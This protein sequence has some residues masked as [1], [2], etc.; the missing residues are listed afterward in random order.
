MKKFVI[1]DLDGTLLNTLEDLKDSTNFALSEFGYPERTLDEVRSFVGNGVRKL[2]ERAVPP[3]CDNVEEC[4]ECF[5]NHYSE[6]MYNKTAPYD[7]I[8]EV[9]KEL[10]ARGLKIGVVSNKF[11]F[12]VKELCKKYF[13]GLIDAAIG[14]SDEIAK[15]PAPDG[16]LKVMEILGA[17]KDFTIYVGDSDVDVQT[18]KNANLPCVGVTW[19]FR[20]RENLS[21]ADFIID[22]P[23]DIINIILKISSSHC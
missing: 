4:L 6:N 14:Q 11:D 7:G 5:K 15:K 3:D 8:V 23:C 12:A 13:D 19:G 18:A 9:L 20:D 17:E 2:I 22:K 21:G 1:F 16:V 10:R